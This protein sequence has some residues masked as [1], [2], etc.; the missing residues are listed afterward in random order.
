MTSLGG[1]PSVG[2][3]IV[4]KPTPLPRRK[5]RLPLRCSI[6]DKFGVLRFS[7]RSLE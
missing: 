4:D 2:T 7:T 3:S 5:A 1:Q 6:D